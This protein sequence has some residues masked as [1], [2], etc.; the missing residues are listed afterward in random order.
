MSCSTTKKKSEVK[1]IK[2]LYHN[3]TARFNGY[4]NANEIM[5][6]TKL[7]LQDMHVDNYNRVLEVYDYVDVDNPKSVSA[8][9][10]KAIEKVSTVATIHDVSNFVDDCYL[11]IGKAQYMKQDYIAA[12]ETLLYFEE[13]FDPKNPYGRAYD[14]SSRRKS[15]GR[16]SKKEI[17]A[18]RK[19]KEK[20][21]K[22]LK[23]EKEAEQKEKDKQRKEEAKTREQERKEKEK[24]RKERAKER[25]KQ[26]K[27]R[28]KRSKS[29]SRSDRD[30]SD[31]SSTEKKTETVETPTETKTEL[32]EQQK[33][34]L[35]EKAEADRLAIEEAEKRAELEAEKEEKKK[36][37]EEKY[38]NQGHGALFKNMSA[39][40]EGLYWLART[41]ICLLYTSPSPRDA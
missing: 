28:K 25:K 1:G 29:R 15:S 27:D 2:K 30:K 39:Y 33:A 18:E 35:E 36:K 3:T 10:D 26:S 9:M 13:V 37:E 5:K 24:E 20:E 8:D 22:E 12:E 41:Y 32:T 14:S 40:T 23:K 21:R 6:E 7:K 19:E 38:K 4:F 11:M 31:K 16:K 34:L 17:Q